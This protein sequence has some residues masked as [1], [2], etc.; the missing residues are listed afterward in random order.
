[1]ATMICQAETEMGLDSF[2]C[3]TDGGVGKPTPGVRV[4]PDKEVARDADIHVIHS[5]VPDDMPGKKVMI[6]HGTP[7][8]CFQV[9]TESMK[10]NYAGSDAFS[11]TTYWINRADA[12]VTFWPRHAALWQTVAPKQKIN[13]IPMGVNKE[14][15]SSGESKGKWVGSPSVFNCENGHSIKWPLD[16]FLAWPMV[17]KEATGARLHAHYL[18]HDM[19]RFWYPL[20]YLNGTA[21]HS[22]S[23]STY[24]G[25]ESLRNGFK[26]SDFYLSPVRYGDHNTICMEAKA[27]GAK[28]ISYKGN[29]YADYWISEGDQRVMAE[30]LIS[31]FKG[32]VEPRTSEPVADIKETAQAMKGLY[33]SL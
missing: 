10:T 27:A 16:I 4:L 22:Y 13:V 29:V 31:I 20:M 11:L 7:E 33:E 14:F 8:H 24:F 15:W 9:T 12:V 30:E 25:P 19:H 23:G 3:Y 2:L 1:M 18:P 5:H 28:V 6:P 26:S 17:T 21:Y 32:E